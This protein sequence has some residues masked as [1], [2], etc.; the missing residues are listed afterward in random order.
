MFLTAF[1]ERVAAAVSSTGVSPHMSD[2]RR[3]GGGRLS[4]LRLTEPEEPVRRA[5]WDY[6]DLIALCAPRA[7]LM[8][9][10]WND[11]YNPNAWPTMACAYHASEVYKLLGCPERL[12]LVEHG[13]GHDT[14]PNLRTIA[15]AWLDRFLRPEEHDERL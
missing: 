11:R 1:D 10:A 7:L 14:P 13:E 12:T 3:H 6:Q 9:E 2:V 5:P 15:Y 4:M 8:L